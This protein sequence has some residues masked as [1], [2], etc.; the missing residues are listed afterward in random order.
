MST[1][2]EEPHNHE[3]HREP[4]LCCKPL[5]PKGSTP[6]RS[7]AADHPAIYPELWVQIS[8][9]PLRPWKAAWKQLIFRQATLVL[10]HLEEPRMRLPISTLFIHAFLPVWLNPPCS[11]NLPTSGQQSIFSLNSDEV[12]ELTGFDKSFSNRH[13]PAI[14]KPR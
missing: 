14:V 10:G 7:G 6:P 1:N 3:S 4:T 12:S 8:M 2:I 9:L 5:P 11:H 13:F